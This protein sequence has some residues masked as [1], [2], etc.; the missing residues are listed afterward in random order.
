MDQATFIKQY[1]TNRANTNSLKWD[2]LDQRYGNPDLIAMWVADMEFQVPQAVTQ[3]LQARVAHGIYGYSY[4]PDSLLRR[5]NRLGAAPSR[6]ALGKELDSLW[7]RGRQLVVRP[8]QYLYTTGRRC[9]DFDPGVLPV[10][11]RDSR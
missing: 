8:D 1:A 9:A 3:A 11:Q 5:V 10:L 7:Y 6:S 4:T 2:A